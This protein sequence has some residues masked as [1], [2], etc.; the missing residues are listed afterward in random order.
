MS[1]ESFSEL[2]REGWQRNAA[3][4]DAVD[5]PATRQSFAPLLDS[6]G[7]LRGRH[8]LEVASGTGHLAEAV[9]RRGATVVG[10]D[11][12]PNMVALAR[13]RVPGATFHEGNAEALPFEDAQFDF[14]FCCFGLLHFAQ[15]AQA[16][17][18]MAR[19]LRPGG[20]VLFTVWCPPEQGN[21]FMGLL[22]TAFQ[23]HANLEVDLPPAP[24][25]F[26]MAD[27]GVRDPMLAAAGFKAITAQL[28]PIMW[29]IHGPE[30]PIDFVL[31]GAVRWR[32]IYDRQTTRVQ[33]RIR[34]TLAAATVPFVGAG[35]IPAAAVLV[36][37][38]KA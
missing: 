26:A 1:H 21:E 38:S 28:I 19:V 23:S 30:T 10:I 12:A 2:E 8:V 36:T 17:R 11:V 6:A 7:N 33:E 14:V 32:M 18:E 22:Y 35:G 20:S 13:R 31:R 24:P 29:P 37:A 5:L 16:L 3:D 4:Y 9:L 25:I 34:E 15:P 27:P